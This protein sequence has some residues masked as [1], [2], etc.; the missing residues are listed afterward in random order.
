MYYSHENEFHAGR[1]TANVTVNFYLS[2]NMLLPP[3]SLPLTTAPPPMN[4]PK[5]ANSVGWLFY[6]VLDSFFSGL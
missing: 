1:F 5:H 3:P 4:E 6:I 2:L